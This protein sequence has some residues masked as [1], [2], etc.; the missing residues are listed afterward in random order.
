MGIFQEASVSHDEEPE[1]SLGAD[2][3]LH[4]PKTMSPNTPQAIEAQL[5]GD[6]EAPLELVERKTKLTEYKDQPGYRVSLDEKRLAGWKLA[7]PIMLL[8]SLMAVGVL[9]VLRP[10]YFSQVIPKTALVIV[11][12]PAGA[13]IRIGSQV[14]GTTPWAGDNIWVGTQK[15]T[16]TQDGFRD[17]SKTF[18]GQRDATLNVAME[19]R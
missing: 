10:R 6:D 18:Q 7:I 4:G 5:R 17:A 14:L 11:S 16:L 19:K 12:E 8:L 9:S 3:T 15:V 2:G 13:T 1:R